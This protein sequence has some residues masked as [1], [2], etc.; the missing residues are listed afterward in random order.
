MKYLLDT[1]ILSEAIKRKPDPNVMQWLESCTE[2]DVYIS[3]LTLGE[4]HKGILR[5]QDQTRKKLLEFWLLNE[6]LRRFAGRVLDVDTEVALSWG[7]QLAESE[8]KGLTLPAIDSLIA[9]TAQK[10][11]LIMVTRNTR[12]FERCNIQCLNPFTDE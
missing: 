11:G 6:L 3:S 10:H 9:A 4:L 7:K 5:L 12:D 2:E 8:Q 1:C